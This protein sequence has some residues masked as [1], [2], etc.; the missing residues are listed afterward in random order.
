M[1]PDKQLI[2]HCPDEG[3]YGDCQRTCI[4]VILDLHP[5]EVPH[6]NDDPRAERGTD[7]WWE[8]RQAAWLAERGLAYATVAYSGE[9]PLGN[10]MEW[11]SKQSPTVPM[12]LLG[13]SRL[14]SN[15][16]VVVMDGEIVC[17]PSGNGIVGPSREGT[18]EVSMITVGPNWGG[19]HDRNSSI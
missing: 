19:R 8:R 18:W 10:V 15:H 11:T 16:V 12:I 9:Q 7:A 6:F 2:E 1:T 3:R 13:T 17:D 5:S 4:A 14:G